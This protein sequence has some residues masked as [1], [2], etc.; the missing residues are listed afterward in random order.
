MIDTICIH[1]KKFHTSTY[2]SGRIVKLVGY[3]RTKLIE[4]NVALLKLKITMIGN[5][6]EALPRLHS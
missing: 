2:R 4:S 1:R 6:G 3:L 5:A